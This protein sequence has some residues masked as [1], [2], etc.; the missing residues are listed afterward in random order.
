MLP[1]LHGRVRLFERNALRDCIGRVYRAI[2]E[3]FGNDTSLHQCHV[4]PLI[5]HPG[6]WKGEDVQLR[7]WF[8]NNIGRYVA[9]HSPVELPRHLARKLHIN[10][11]DLRGVTVMHYL[12]ALP[13]EKW[14]L[15]LHDLHVLLV[16]KLDYKPH[17]AISNSGLPSI[18]LSVGLP[19]GIRHIAQ[20]GL[21]VTH[22]NLLSGGF[23][24]SNSESSGVSDN[25]PSKRPR[26]DS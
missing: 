17:D 7:D 15:C 22:K 21:S 18:D 5:V 8:Y 19:N 16:E 3:K 14:P 2:D 9:G 24:W 13:K 1:E 12:S 20:E 10:K 25:V 26:L 6:P 11:Y 4:A 23:C